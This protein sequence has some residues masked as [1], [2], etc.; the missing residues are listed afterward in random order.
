MFTLRRPQQ[1]ISQIRHI[2]TNSIQFLSFFISR[3]TLF[4]FW[5]KTIFKNR[6]HSF[7]LQKKAWLVILDGQFCL[8]LCVMRCVYLSKKKNL[9]DDS[10]P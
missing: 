10:V 9:L 7:V 4:C 8:V 2:D 6:T 1:F 3:S 5:W